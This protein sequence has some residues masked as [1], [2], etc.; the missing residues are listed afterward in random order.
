MCSNIDTANLLVYNRAPRHAY[1][2]IAFEWVF[3]QTQH[4]TSFSMLCKFNFIWGYWSTGRL[5]VYLYSILAYREHDKMEV[6]GAEVVVFMVAIVRVLLFV[7]STQCGWY[8]LTGS[9]IDMC[10]YSQGEASP[11]N[12]WR[13]LRG[14]GAAVTNLCLSWKLFGIRNGVHS[15]Y[16]SLK[17]SDCLCITILCIMYALAYSGYRAHRSNDL[18]IMWNG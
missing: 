9:V 4:V 3:S 12:G 8:R 18:F 15:Y 2:C 11:N 13:K 5:F 17:F 10:V 6:M 16:V 14:V 7:P 1:M